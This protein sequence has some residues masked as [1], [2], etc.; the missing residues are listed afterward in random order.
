MVSKF[1]AFF[2]SRRIAIAVA[3]IVAISTLVS[4]LQNAGSVTVRA[5]GT[6]I[7]IPVMP[8][9]LT[10]RGTQ[11]L[12]VN[13][14]MGLAA[15]PQ[16]YGYVDYSDKVAA[17][18]SQYAYVVIEPSGCEEY[19][20]NVRIRYD[21]FLTPDG[22]RYEDRHLY[23][24]DWDSPEAQA[25]YK[26]KVDEEGI[27]VNQVQYDKWLDSLPHIW[28]DSP[29]HS[30][31]C[32]FSPD[33]TDNEIKSAGLYHLG[34]FYTAWCDDWVDVQGGMRH[35]WDVETRI[36][37]IRYDQDPTYLEYD[38]LKADCEARVAEAKT[39]DISK[40][41]GIGELLGETFP[42]TEIDIGAGAV[43][44]SYYVNLVNAFV[45]L[46]NPANETGSLDTIEAWVYT[47]FS[48]FIVGTFNLV[49]GTT[50]EC[51]D[52]DTIGSITSGAK[53]TFTGLDISV[54]TAGLLG[55]YKDSGNYE[56]DKTGYLGFR[57]AG[58]ADA[59]VP[60]TQTNFTGLSS[61][62]ALSFYGTG[63]TV[64]TCEEDISNTPSSE[65]LG[66]IAA[67]STIYAYGSAPS[68]PVED[69]ECTF[70]ITNSSGGAVD[71]TMKATNFTGGTGWTLT[72]DSPGEDTVRVTA[73]YSGQNPA[74]GVVLTTSYQTFKEG[75]ADSA[76]LKWDFK[77]E[78]GTFTDGVQKSGT[79]TVLATCQ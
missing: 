14:S 16:S 71:L 79:I 44:R 57:Y 49:S 25:G 59:L 48:G 11:F 31:F 17:D 58:F 68:N 70:T 6:N 10:I 38:T 1:K 54:T 13:S 26:G 46:N 27:P 29:F 15:T 19:H 52:S 30:H 63:E 69:G 66:T 45:D 43:N 41:A 47:N 37:P 76:T 55:G 5:E 35:G 36:R 64:P 9:Q 65:N 34:N 53:R 51:E 72:G 56:W 24:P 50:Y 18:V 75:V 20:G 40:E 8:K 39:L 78:T 22:Y 21:F 60:T 74:S 67:S 12:A 23:V 3:I 62:D 32:Y 4:P 33:V 7:V 73:Y 28:Q 77:L 2:T 42:A 61:G